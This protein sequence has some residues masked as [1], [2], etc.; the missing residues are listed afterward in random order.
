MLLEKLIAA[1]IG[2]R[3]VLF[4]T[5]RSVSAYIYFLPSFSVILSLM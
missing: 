4:V 2:D 1:G 5:H 3:P